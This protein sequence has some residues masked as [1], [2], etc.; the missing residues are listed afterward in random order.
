M[1]NQQIDSELADFVNFEQQKQQLQTQV[2]KL[3]EVCWDKCMDKPKDKLD[4]RTEGCVSNCVERFMDTSIAIVGRF[5]QMLQK[6]M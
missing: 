6:Q 5:Q 1:E 3:T 4:Y 2:H